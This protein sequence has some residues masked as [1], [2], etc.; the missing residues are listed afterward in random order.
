MISYKA[1]HVYN[2]LDPTAY[3]P[4]GQTPVYRPVGSQ[5]RPVFLWQPYLPPSPSFD[6]WYGPA[7]P[8][9]TP[10]DY[11]DDKSDPSSAESPSTATSVDYQL[12]TAF[13]AAWAA[14]GTESGAI[15]GIASPSSD[16]GINSS[17]G[18]TGYSHPVIPAVK[19]EYVVGWG[20]AL[21]GQCLDQGSMV[22]LPSPFPLPWQDDMK[23]KPPAYKTKPCKFYTTNGKCAS[24][25]KCTFIHDPESKGNAEKSPTE[26][27]PPTE[28]RLPPKPLNKYDDSR[29]KD[30]YPITWRVIG[31]GVMMGGQSEST[32]A[33]SRARAEWGPG[34]ICPAFAAGHCKYGNDCK[35]AHETELETDRECCGVFDGRDL[36]RAHLSKVGFI[37][38]K[39]ETVQNAE[40]SPQKPTKG[41]TSKRSQRR[42]STKVPSSETQRGEIFPSTTPHPRRPTLEGVETTGKKVNEVVVPSAR[43]APTSPVRRRTRSMSMVLTS[44]PP[45]DTAHPNYAAEL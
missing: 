30:F 21:S 37:E 43:D 20:R 39:S 45:L 44:P 19:A 38:P 18:Y 9:E 7:R 23:K 35:L 5:M 16:L 36:T 26:L 17:P 6:P 10:L 27:A 41:T 8:V 3:H 34:Q 24:E 12:R 31:G 40:G 13:D 22:T 29:A 42:K 32:H 11:S 2:Y 4:A 1:E 15:R 33:R 14:E 28:A 25:E